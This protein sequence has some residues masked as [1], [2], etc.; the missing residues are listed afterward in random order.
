MLNMKIQL[1]SCKI[2]IA[3]KK[4]GIWMCMFMFLAK[5]NYLFKPSFPH[6]TDFSQ[7]YC[8][9]QLVQQ[10][11]YSNETLRKYHCKCEAFKKVAYKFM[12]PKGLSTNWHKNLFYNQICRN[13]LMDN[14][15]IIPHSLFQKRCYVLFEHVTMYTVG[16]HRAGGYELFSYFSINL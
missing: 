15:D 9:N 14:Y 6:P 5:Y 11:W 1:R 7:G 12:K 10:V 13:Y 2:A 4:E 16:L 3:V 8:S